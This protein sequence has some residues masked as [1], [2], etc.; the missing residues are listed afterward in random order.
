M[1]EFDKNKIFTHLIARH[2]NKNHQEQSIPD[3]WAKIFS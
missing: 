3:D 1:Q 2:I